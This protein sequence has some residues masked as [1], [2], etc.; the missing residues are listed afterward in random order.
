MIDPAVADFTGKNLFS[1]ALEPL[2]L[3]SGPH[4]LKVL[5]TAIFRDQIRLEWLEQDT[6]RNLGSN[7]VTQPCRSTPRRS[8]YN[9]GFLQIRIRIDVEAAAN[10]LNDPPAIFSKP[11]L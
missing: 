4:V 3:D 1:K 8:G 6:T 10:M 7:Q 2:I 5:E 9:N 11:K